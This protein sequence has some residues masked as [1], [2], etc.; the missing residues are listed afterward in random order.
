MSKRTTIREA[1]GSYEYF[2]VRIVGTAPILIAH[3]LPWDIGGA[4][5][6]E[7][8]ADTRQHK[9]KIEV[10]TDSQRDLL[11]KLKVS[12]NGHLT[13][14]AEAHLRGHWLPDLRPGFPVSGFMG[15]C[16][17]GIVQH[18]GKS[19]NALSGKKA[20]GAFAIIGHDTCPELVAL[21][22][23]YAIR[24]DMAKNSGG[25]GGTGAP[26]I[27]TR[28]EVAIGW[29]AELRIRFNVDLINEQTIGQAISWG[30]DYGVGQWRPGSPKGGT[31][32]T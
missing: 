2:A 26:R 27:A 32:G 10:I 29:E 24:R 5:W 14:E 13:D 31:F 9:R 25:Y 12:V 1:S 3:P 19:K 17:T 28:I 18:K 11:K 4:F 7:Q 23:A 6:D 22:G 20:A 16:R 30:G 15:A 21:D 8:S